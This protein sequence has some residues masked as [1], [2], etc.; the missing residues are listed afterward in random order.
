MS[1]HYII[2]G[3][4]CCDH[5]FEVPLDYQLPCEQQLTIYVREVAS[6][7]AIDNQLP[8]LVY[9]Q[10]GP[11]FGAGRPTG[12]DGWIKEASKH[13]RILLLD[14]RGTANSSPVTAQTLV[15]MTCE[16]QA[17]YLS[18]FRADNIVRDAEFIRQQLIGE[19]K[20][21]IIGQSFGGFCVIRY[22]SSAP[23]GLSQAFIT[24]GIPSLTR[25]AEDVY[26]ATFPR[27]ANR[28]AKFFAQYPKAQ[29][30]A[31]AIADHLLQYRE[32]MPNGTVLT[33]EQFQL[34]GIHLGMTGGHQELYFLMEQA[35]AD[36][37]GRKELSYYFKHQLMGLLDYDTNPIFAFLHESI[38]CQQFA[39]NWA[40]HHVRE[41]THSE[42]FNYSGGEQAFNFTGEM[43]FPWMFEQF[44]NLKP[45][46][47]AAQLLAK[48][49]DWPMLYDLEVLK[50]NTV[51]TAAAI[52]FDDMYVDINYCL[53]TVAQIAN[54]ETW[55]SS[56]YDHNGI[57]VGGEL[58]FNKLYGLLNP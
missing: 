7:F 10:G 25:S 12:L 1:S 43:I 5:Y 29:A 11:G 9:F 53:E 42:L 57:R 22:L 6:Q 26:Q 13:Y 35:F 21:S 27:V 40:A 54:I 8:Y 41:N 15:A 16:Q 3:L 45:L 46:Q 51:P 47:G 17:D 28:N 49:D 36:V 32:L 33:V 30:M 56:D 44:A 50:N 52:Y 31:K 58:I 2:N 48:K 38:Y 23:E 34:L 19:N 24:G 37:D 4:R 20:W 18:H 39:S 55:V 14:Q